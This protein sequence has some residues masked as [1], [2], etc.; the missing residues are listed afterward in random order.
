MKDTITASIILLLD[1]GIKKITKE[2]NSLEGARQWT[3]KMFENSRCYIDAYYVQGRCFAS[4]VTWNDDLSSWVKN[5][6]EEWNKFNAE[7]TLDGTIQD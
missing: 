2:F 4:T 5:H 6:S 1:S 3:S 7:E